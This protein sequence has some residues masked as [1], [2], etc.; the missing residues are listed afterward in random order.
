MKTLGGTKPRCGW[1]Q[2]ISASKPTSFWVLALTSGWIDEVELLGGDRAA[3]VGFQPDPVV[4][5]GLQFRREIFGDAAAGALGFVQRKVGLEDQIVDGRPVDR[6][7]GA[8]DRD[9]DPDFGLVD[10][11]RFLDRPD[12]AVGQLLDL[13][14]RLRIGDDDRELVAAHASDM[15]VLADLVAQPLG[16]RLEHRVALGMAECIVDRFEPV[17]IE[18][19]DRAG[20]IAGR[21]VAQR[22]AE[23][24]ADPATIGQARQ[25]VHVGEVGQAFLRLANFGDVAADAAEALEPAGGIDDRIAGDRDPAWAARGLQL[26]LKIVERLLLQQHA[27][28]LRM[29][30]EQR[31]HRMAEQRAGGAAEQCGHPAGDVGYA[32]FAIDLPQPAHAALLIFLQ[33]QAGAFR[34]GTEIGIGLEL[35]EGPAGDGQDADDGDA[36]REQDGQA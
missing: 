22:F 30:A 21:G 20:H 4:L 23:Q 33:Q 26:H 35:A 11:V 5:F 25:Y 8:A 6:T 10:H 9:A 16:D 34:L 12:D 13:L 14:A 28:E 2:R 29:A 27:A 32:I 24:L 7:E 18:E 19:H 17:E 1:F 31:R 36:Q 3:K 15:A